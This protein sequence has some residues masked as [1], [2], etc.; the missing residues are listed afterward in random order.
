MSYNRGRMGL[1]SYANGS[2]DPDDELYR[3]LIRRLRGG[4]APPTIHSY[5]PDIDETIW[6]LITE[7]GATPTSP[8]WLDLPDNPEDFFKAEGN[9]AHYLRRKPDPTDPLRL[10]GK[11]GT[12]TPLDLDPWQT[13]PEHMLVPRNRR[14][15]PLNMKFTDPNYPIHRFRDQCPSIMDKSI[16]HRTERLWDDPN[17]PTDRFQDQW[18]SV[19]DLPP[20]E[21]LPPGK[22]LPPG[23]IDLDSDILDR[24][25][26]FPGGRTQGIEGADLGEYP[27]ISDWWDEQVARQEADKVLEPPTGRPPANRLRHLAEPTHP[28]SPVAEK[29][30]NKLISEIE[31]I[32]SRIEGYTAD[33]LMPPK[34]LFDELDAYNRLLESPLAGVGSYDDFDVLDY[35]SDMYSKI[36]M[37]QTGDVVGVTTI[38]PQAAAQRYETRLAA[39]EAAEKAAKKAAARKAAIRGAVIA[40]ASTLALPAELAAEFALFPEEMGGR[41]ASQ[42]RNTYMSQQEMDREDLDLQPYVDIHGTGPDIW[43]N[44]LGRSPSSQA[45]IAEFLRQNRAGTPVNRYRR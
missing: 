35:D 4:E 37:G 8:Y 11:D 24:P 34:G 26:R 10:F 1:R 33:G 16:G 42:P 27:G 30:R 45:D 20:A 40:G 22:H 3:Q 25:D 17:F 39:R 12:P 9:R 2:P 13:R 43:D 6:R 15:H 7:S 29:F 44:P 38:D 21:R 41:E 32:H 14:D 19:I 5:G 31:S 28:I 23:Y 18:E 36:P